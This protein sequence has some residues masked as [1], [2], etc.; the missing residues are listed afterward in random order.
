[1]AA[2]EVA[3]LVEAAAA[4]VVAAGNI[5]SPTH[6]AFSVHVVLLFF[7]YTYLQHLSKHQ[8]VYDLQKENSDT[9]LAMPS[10]F[11]LTLRHLFRYY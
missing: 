6:S 2:V 9:F 11:H 5:N 7:D 3:A 1:L 4:A 10:Y 8:H